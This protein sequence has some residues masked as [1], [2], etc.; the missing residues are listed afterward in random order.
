MACFSPRS[1]LQHPLLARFRPLSGSVP[2]NSF[3]VWEYWRLAGTEQIKGANVVIPYSDGRPALLERLVGRG[4]VLVMTTPVSDAACDP[5][6]LESVGHRVQ[7]L[8]VR[9]ALE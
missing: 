9:H 4:R 5:D 6:C 3:P 8:A 2:W 1:D 7:A